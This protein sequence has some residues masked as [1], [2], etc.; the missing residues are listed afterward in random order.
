MESKISTVIGEGTYGCVHDPS[1]KCKN[2]PGIS[3]ENK[4]SKVL[5]TKDADQELGEYKKVSEVDKNLD[6]Y[7]GVPE[8]CSIDNKNIFNLK[9]IQKCKIGT[10]V[11]K[12][13][14]SS[15]YKM[16]VMKNGGI[17]LEKYCKV[18]EKWSNSE[19]STE[20]CEK[21]LLET[22]RLFK[23][24]V[25]FEKHGLIHHDLKPQNIVYNEKTNRVNFIDFGLMISR[26][27][28][29][30][31]AEDSVYDLGIYHWS[32]PWEME[33]LNKDDYDKVYN[34]IDEQD[35][36]L[37]EISDQIK[38]KKGKYYENCRSFFYFVIDPTISL[39]EYQEECLQYINGYSRTLKENLKSMQYKDF[40]NSCLKTIDVYGLGI[41]LMHWLNAAKRFVD[42]NLFDDLNSLYSK[43]IEPELK[44]RITIDPALN[45]MK[46]ILS[47]NGILEKYNKK[48][49]DNL[50]VDKPITPI[51]PVLKI[52][53]NIFKK[54]TSPIREVVNRDPGACPEGK[55]R[56]PKTRRCVKKC[57]PGYTRDENFKCVK[58]KVAKVDKSKAPCPEGKE[59]NPKTRR[60]VKKCN[61]GYARDE[62]FKCTRNKTS[63]LHQ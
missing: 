27:K 44:L 25:L 50:S 37:N 40:L 60:C 6:F 21:F 20:L 35:K 2:A 17:D 54:A 58:V 5:K 29:R 43:M 7:L 36:I 56:N 63:K 3:Y 41:A 48:I 49:V 4:I 59:R 30:T 53:K 16:L 55:E 22:L 9:S 57:K 45:E 42:K 34:S 39:D 32:Y 52:E 23:G 33:V 24:I 18:M 31:A 1:L 62:N 46:T 28:V 19:M 8:A 11:I 47:K 38:Q 10:S 61:P 14:S 12:K 51:Q 13:L 15:E 26:D